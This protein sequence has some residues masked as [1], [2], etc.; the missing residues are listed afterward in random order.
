ME[1]EL[2][3]FLSSPAA[4]APNSQGTP[5]SFVMDRL[6]YPPNSHDMNEEGKEEVYFLAQVLRAHPT[7]EIEIRGHD[8][9]TEAEAYSGP[10][11]YRGYT[12]SKLRA[13]CVL[14]RLEGFSIAPERMH[15]TGVA[16]AEPLKDA[17]E[18]TEIGRQKNRRVE[19]VVL[20]R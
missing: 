15:I 5:R 14:R 11:P 12:L 3:E 7:A 13:D 10:N 17:D 16:A 20:R 18:H 1:A 19:I 6:H 4:A 9:G 2:E 8:D